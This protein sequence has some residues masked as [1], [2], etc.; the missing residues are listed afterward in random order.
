MEMDEEKVNA[1][2]NWLVPVDLKQFQ[3]FLGFANLYHHIIRKHSQVVAALHA[4]TS[5]NPQVPWAWGSHFF[6]TVQILLIADPTDDTKIQFTVE[7]DASD[8]GVR[9]ILFQKLAGNNKVHP[10]HFYSRKLSS[11]EQNYDVDSPHH[12]GQIGLDIASSHS[13][14][15]P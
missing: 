7:V 4:I 5:S 10:C 9:A 1:V 8:V 3:W 2:L 12:G 13:L 6:S 14:D 11:A 15:W